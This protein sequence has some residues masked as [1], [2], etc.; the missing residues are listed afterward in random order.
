MPDGLLRQHLLSDGERQANSLE[1]VR[2]NVVA[3]YPAD[4][5]MGSVTDDQAQRLVRNLW[6]G[7]AMGLHGSAPVGRGRADWG[8]PLRTVALQIMM[9]IYVNL[10]EPKTADVVLLAR[11]SRRTLHPSGLITVR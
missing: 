4:D 6:V 2:R 10:V 8:L 1:S 5:A 7:W 11:R 9:S 3:E